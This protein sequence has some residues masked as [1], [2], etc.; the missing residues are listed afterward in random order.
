MRRGTWCSGTGSEPLAGS[1]RLERC[2]SS[3]AWRSE[4]V[5]QDR[6]AR[7][8]ILALRRPMDVKSRGMRVRA[9]VRALSA[10]VGAIGAFMPA[11]A[12][13]QAT[14]QQAATQERTRLLQAQRDAVSQL[15]Q[16]ARPDA[17]HDQV[18][19][20][21]QTASRSLNTLGAATTILDPSLRND[22]RRAAGEVASLASA[23]TPRSVAAAPRS[24]LAL[25]DKARAQ[26]EA[27]VARGLPFEG[28]FSQ[29]K[30][31]EP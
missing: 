3:L 12:A 28:S 1:R 7:G 14:A 8:I 23:A 2:R 24:T 22:L 17:R 26:L 29:T 27:D 10:S 16:A 5:S 6:S 4:A 25:L 30:P 9:I 11:T 15:Q 18:Q 19:R 21:L 20:A 31:K 13:E